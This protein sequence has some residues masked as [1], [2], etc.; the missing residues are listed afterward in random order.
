[1]SLIISHFSFI[2]NFD[3]KDIYVILSNE[4]SKKEKSFPDRGSRPQTSVATSTRSRSP[5]LKVARKTF[6]RKLAHTALI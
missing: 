3:I 2:L 4:K 1:M 6:S 5:T